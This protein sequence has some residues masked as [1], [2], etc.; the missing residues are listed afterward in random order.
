MKHDPN[1]FAGALARFREFAGLTQL[2][3]AK[4]SQT[5]HS[6]VNRWEKGGSLP[7]RD[8]AEALDE[9]L[10]AEGVLLA[11]WRAVATGNGLPEWARDLD[12]IERAARQVT[13]VVP[14]LVPGMLQNSE[15]ARCVF[16]AAHPLAT[17]DELDRLVALRTGRLKELPELEVTAVFPV[18]AVSALTEPL[19]RPQGASPH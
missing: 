12:A 6:S 1:D 2:Q 16:R 3:L 19:R 17:A 15:V 10:G 8:N 11:A 7:K 5:A 13:I 14:A 18:T 9:A 4:K